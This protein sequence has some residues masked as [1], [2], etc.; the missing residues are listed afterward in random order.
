M[1]RF[2]LKELVVCLSTLTIPS[3]GL[4]YNP[5][6][7]YN[8]KP[9]NYQENQE[10]KTIEQ[11]Q[12]E[13]KD[14]LEKIKKTLETRY[15]IKKGEGLPATEI[16]EVFK[17]PGEEN[18]YLAISF[19][20]WDKKGIDSFAIRSGII[21]VKEGKVVTVKDYDTKTP[22]DVKLED[23]VGTIKNLT[24]KKLYSDDS[25]YFACR[26]AWYELTSALTYS[27]QVK[28]IRIEDR[29]ESGLG[30]ADIYN[31]EIETGT[32]TLTSNPNQA[33]KDYYYLLKILHDDILQLK[34]TK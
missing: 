19:A 24:G 26:V 21:K 6:L 25:K 8:P 28:Q 2:G 32:I 3:V 17:L 20:D 5:P 14:M 10:E 9:S 33:T 29:K 7:N 27:E 13:N 30:E 15:E 23:I 1:T 4:T 11:Y 22:K 34:N 18:A 12:K 16:F 31:R